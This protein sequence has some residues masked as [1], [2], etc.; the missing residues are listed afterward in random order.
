M[1]NHLMEWKW[2]EMSGLTQ[3]P[4]VLLLALPQVQCEAPKISKLVY[5]FN[6]YGLW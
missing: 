1:L 3:S 4:V 2:S 6:N 5:N